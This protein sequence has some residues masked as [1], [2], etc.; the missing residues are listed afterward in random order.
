VRFFI[1]YFV[2]PLVLL[3]KKPEPGDSLIMGK[4]IQRTGT[5]TETNHH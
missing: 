1:G 2:K 5:N 4:K 3:L